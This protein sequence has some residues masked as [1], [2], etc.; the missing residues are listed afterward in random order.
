MSL[1][2]KWK[3]IEGNNVILNASELNISITAV[4]DM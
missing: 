1:A 4:S 2:I 3:K